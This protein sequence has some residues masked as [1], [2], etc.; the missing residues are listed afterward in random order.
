MC[1]CMCCAGVCVSVCLCAC[2]QMQVEEEIFLD[3]EA[4]LI[5]QCRKTLATSSDEISCRSSPA[6][7]WDYSMFDYEG[8]NM[9]QLCS[10]NR[11]TAASS[12]HEALSNNRIVQE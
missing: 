6:S 10:T 8:S 11:K 1:V 4:R 9:L 7:I 2:V 5:Q 12:E 3:L